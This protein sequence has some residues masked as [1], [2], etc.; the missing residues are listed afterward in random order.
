MLQT[1]SRLS[2]LP[3]CLLLVLSLSACATAPQASSLSGV[4]DTEI[5]K[6]LWRGTDGASIYRVA[7]EPAARIPLDQPVQ[8]D[9]AWLRTFLASLELVYES[10]D[11]SVELT[12][13]NDEQLDRLVPA[14][15]RGLAHTGPD[16]EIVFTVAGPL[17]GARIFPQ[18]VATSGR[19]FV[20][21]GHL[22]IIFGRALQTVFDQ[23]AKRDV[24]TPGSR[25]AVQLEPGHKV[26]STLWAADLERRDW[27][28]IELQRGSG[29]LPALPESV[30]VATDAPAPGTGTGGGA[31]AA[32]A[33]SLSVREKLEMLKRLYEDEL[34]TREEYA[35]ERAEVLDAL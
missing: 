33:A 7:A 18:T 29:P 8:P 10:S 12:L 21:D 19:V 11:R 1:V 5:V 27:V 16:R 35:R 15:V 2:C 17:P 24:Y 6:V 14:L 4:T 32:P 26:R 13:F 34:I 30:P 20:A 9:A 3:A 25:R 31:A 23:S 22:N 28:R